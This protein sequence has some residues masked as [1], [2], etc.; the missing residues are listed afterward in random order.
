MSLTRRA[1]LSLCAAGGAGAVGASRAAA[2]EPFAWRRFGDLLRARFTDLRRHF[3]FDYYPWYAADPFRHWTM[4]HRVPPDDLAAN[5]MPLLGAYDSRSRDVVEQHARWIADSGVG[6]INVSWWGQGSFSDRTV[7]LLMDVMGDH[8]IQVTFHLEP[9]SLDRATR[10]PE[11]VLYLLREYGEK[12]RWDHFYFNER[13]DGTQGP[14]IKL[15]RTTTS[16]RVANCHGEIEAVAD[17]VP[18]GDWRRQTDR[19]REVVNGDFDHLTLLSNSPRVERVVAAGFDG[20][21]IYDPADTP[22]Q[23]LD[24]ALAATREGALFAF[25]INP[26][27]DYVE[28]RVVEPNSCYAPPPFLPASSEFDWNRAEDRERAAQ[29]AEQRIE[30]SLQTNLVLQT[31]PWLGNVDRGFFLTHITSFNEWHEG[32]QF[33]PMKDAS[34]LNS[35]ERAVGYHNP[36]DGAYRMRKLVDLLGEL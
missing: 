11:D 22:D 5:T 9:Y 10:M 4:W 26:G 2:Q 28:R 1:F 3:V 13:A 20:I 35:A 33:E 8:D 32:H 14:V 7:P 23:W 30:E 31:H 19:L 12:R 17:F 15:F 21:S 6:V 36:A 18:D 27:Q 34:A 16:E 24:K 25:P 29:L